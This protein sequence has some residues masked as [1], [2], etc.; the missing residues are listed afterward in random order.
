M[1]A[2]DTTWSTKFSRDQPPSFLARI[3]ILCTSKEG[4]CTDASLQQFHVFV[5]GRLIRLHRAT[6]ATTTRGQHDDGA[7]HLHSRIC[8]H[9]HD[10]PRVCSCR[11]FDVDRIVDAAIATFFIPFPCTHLKK[12]E[13][14]FFPPSPFWK[15]CS[16]LHNFSA[17]RL[18]KLLE[19]RVEPRRGTRME[20]N[21]QI[22]FK[23]SLIYTYIYIYKYIS[24]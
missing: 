13:H 11:I 18:S 14:F 3:W 20:R 9:K 23:L 2:S 6:A 4:R 19:N 8:M 21:F 22:H 10:N 24:M 16:R 15:S 17:A 1:F 7:L 12:R 5:F